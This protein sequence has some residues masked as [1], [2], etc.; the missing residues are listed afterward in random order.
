MAQVKIEIR[1][2]SGGELFIKTFPQARP[3]AKRVVEYWLG[4]HKLT[5]A[6]AAGVLASPRVRE[7]DPAPL[8]PIWTG[9]APLQVAK[10]AKR[11]ER[12]TGRAARQ[13]RAA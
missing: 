1:Q 6:Q 2:V 5:A 11:Y 3:F 8:R 4:R 7:R 9:T 13:R 12:R 10:P